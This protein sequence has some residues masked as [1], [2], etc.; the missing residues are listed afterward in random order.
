MAIEL[1]MH[2][3]KGE[4]CTTTFRF[5]LFKEVAGFCGVESLVLPLPASSDPRRLFLISS[6]TMAISLS[7]RM[8]AM[9]APN[10][11]VWVQPP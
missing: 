9:R 7:R 4:V 6:S 10:A 11:L 3:R 5:R 1:C 2:R 8:L